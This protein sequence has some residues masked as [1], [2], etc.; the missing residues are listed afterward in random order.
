MPHVHKLFL[1]SL[2]LIATSP[3][4]AQNISPYLYGQNHWMADGDEGRVG[5]LKDLWPKVKESGVTI[6][7]IG[8]NGYEKQFPPRDKLNAMID[9]IQSIGAEPLLQVPR[10]F[11]ALQA[12][13]LVEYYT[14]VG[15][16]KVKF[17]SVG[18]EPMLHDQNTLQEVHTFLTR[19]GPAMREVGPDIK[20]FAYDEASLNLPEYTALI[21]GELDITGLKVNDRWVFDGVTFH[22]YPN[23]EKFNRDDVVFSGPNKILG[24]INALKGLISKANEKHQ[25][26]GESALLWGLT[27]VNVTWKNPD[28]EIS[29]YGN[30]SFLGGQFIA[31]IFG[32]AMEHEAYM[33][34]PWCINETDAVATDFGYLGFPREFYPRSSFYHMQMMSENMTG[35]FVANNN[36]QPYVKTIATA[37]K[38]TM[39][40]LVMNQ[41]QKQDF[42]FVISFSSDSAATTRPLAITVDAGLKKAKFEGDIPAQ[43]SIVFVFDK[44]GKLKKTVTYGLKNNLKN[45]TPVV[46]KL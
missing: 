11:T 13:E 28:R 10:D 16:R 41:D 34:N 38:K 20:I 39:A 3:L 7:R 9:N 23:G 12:Q 26:S 17:W 40:V 19:I 29:G 15:T 35:A 2:L 25:R 42:P 21:G 6:V 45:E 22:N 46:S 30:P 27:E 24:Q 8:G 36:N 33:V 37:D 18:N 14:K 44:K 32:Y 4:F 1:A 31:E 5:Y 43:T